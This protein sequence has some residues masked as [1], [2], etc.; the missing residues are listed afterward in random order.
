[1]SKPELKNYLR[2]IH[3]HGGA[4]LDQAARAFQRRMLEDW[5][6]PDG[7]FQDVVERY[8]DALM[9]A[10]DAEGVLDR[11]E[12]GALFDRAFRLL[13]ESYP[14]V[15]AG[16]LAA[17]SALFDLAEQYVRRVMDMAAGFVLRGE[18]VAPVLF[19]FAADGDE[20]LGVGITPLG[21]QKSTWPA[22]IQEIMRRTEGFGHAIVSEASEVKESAAFRRHLAAGGGP[23]DFPD[24]QDVILLVLELPGRRRIF[25]RTISADRSSVGPIEESRVQASRWEGVGGTGGHN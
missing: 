2:L 3:A 1:M 22:V 4:P 25:T 17:P 18:P 10:L 14:G 15:P 8:G 9:A 20:R 12:D 7:I 24:R 6:D 19:V 23:S 11:L 21:P 16:S 13:V 5:P